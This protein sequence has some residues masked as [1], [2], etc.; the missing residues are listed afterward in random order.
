MGYRSWQRFFALVL[1]TL[2]VPFNAWSAGPLGTARA[3]RGVKASL[4]N[5]GTWLEMKGHAL[6]VFAG[7]EVRAGGG[8]AAIELKDGSRIEV[9]PFSSVRFDEVAGEPRMRVTYGRINFRLHPQSRLHVVTP[10]ANLAPA[11]RAGVAGEVFVTGGGVMGLKMAEGRVN[12]QPTTVG[13][14]PM[15]ASLE[16]VFLPKRPQGAGPLFAADGPLTP[17][18]GAKA[19]FAP[20]GDSV[21]YL[22]PDGS[23]AIHPGYTADLTQPFSPK[24][25]R[26]AM[27][28]IPS[29][30]R[31]DATPLFDVNGGYVGY[32][33]GPVFYAQNTSPSPEGTAPATQGGGT[34]GAGKASSVS[35]KFALGA[36]AVA[37]VAGGGVAAM[38]MGG[39]GGGNGGGSAPAQSPAATPFGPR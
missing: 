27:N 24:L 9:L 38:G 10:A 19:V 21:G 17:P 23:L 35:P 34:Q 6:P 15:V 3:A 1:I 5:G 25:V 12:V 33:A 28:T 31:S 37:A 36:G 18:A 26:L 4:D 7:T 2:F 16:P 8:A 20:K 22:G 29:T 30:E 32:L 11:E 39:G 14:A 13:A